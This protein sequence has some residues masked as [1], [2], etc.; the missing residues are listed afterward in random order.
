MDENNEGKRGVNEDFKDF[1]L[2]N[3][4]NGVVVF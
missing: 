4:K 2:S 3:W 1:G